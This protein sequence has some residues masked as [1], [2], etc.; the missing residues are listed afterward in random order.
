MDSSISSNINNF[1]ESYDQSSNPF[2]L[3]K[4][5][6]PSTTADSISPLAST[7]NN[8]VFFYHQQQEKIIQYHYQQHQLK[9]VQYLYH[10]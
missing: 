8:S 7:T 1:Q 10:Q 2:R 3:N 4:S 6:K 5:E 9:T